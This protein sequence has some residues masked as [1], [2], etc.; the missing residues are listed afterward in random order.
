MTPRYPSTRQT[1]LSSS[2][3]YSKLANRPQTQRS[4]NLATFTISTTLQVLDVDRALL[5]S[6]SADAGGRGA[7]QVAGDGSN[8]EILL[9]RQHALVHLFVLFASGRVQVLQEVPT[10]ERRLVLVRPRRRNTA[11]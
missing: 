7:A 10:R 11:P 3:P 8:R 4:S 1:I 2:C 9:D 5:W 6:A